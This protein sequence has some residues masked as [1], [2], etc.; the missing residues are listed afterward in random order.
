MQNVKLILEYDGGGFSGW[1]VQ[2]DRRTVQGELYSVFRELSTCEVK[3]VGAGRTDAGVHAAAQAANALL[4]TKLGLDE[5]MRAVNAKLPPDIRVKRLEE[6]PLHFNARFDARSRT[7][8]YIFI[9]R[10]TALWRDYFYF[11]AGELDIAAMRQAVSRLVGEHDFAAF[12]SAS[13][14]RTGTRC[15]VIRAEISDTYPLLSFSITADHFLHTMVRSL[16]GTLL[17]IAR[18][19]A[20]DI[21]EII[22]ARDRSAVGKVL[23][24]HALYLMGVEY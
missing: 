3:I 18:G 14:E 20:G 17:E 1:Q 4:E 13:D 10:P 9:R 6:V 23:P 19:R 24:P 12:A 2:P 16:A 21:E 8:R 15:R 5:L 11:A 7:Y 22:G